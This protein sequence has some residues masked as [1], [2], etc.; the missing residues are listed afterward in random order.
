MEAGTGGCEA[1]KLEAV[2]LWSEVKVVSVNPDGESHHGHAR[3]KMARKEREDGYK[4]GK[5][6][7]WEGTLGRGCGGSKSERGK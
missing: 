3:A 6:G 2:G 5:E 7:T 1:E 4:N